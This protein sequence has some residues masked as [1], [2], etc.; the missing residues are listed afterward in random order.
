MAITRPPSASSGFTGPINKPTRLL[1]EPV[2]PHPGSFISTRVQGL[3]HAI[4][5]VCPSICVIGQIP[6]S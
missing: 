5:Y 6:L 4:A 3:A 1:H 2:I